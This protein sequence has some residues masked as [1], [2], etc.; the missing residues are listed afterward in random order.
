MNG[1]GIFLRE[2][3][4]FVES[5]FKQ[6]I[7]QGT[8]RIKWHKLCDL[9]CN[10]VNGYPD[11]G[12]GVFTTS[13]GS[14][15]FEGPWSKGFPVFEQT[16]KY[17]WSDLDRSMVK[18]PEPDSDPGKKKAAAPPKKKGAADD[19]EP[20]L[21]AFAGVQLGK[22]VVR[23]G[24]TA[25]NE[26]PVPPPNPKAAKGEPLL[27]PVMP[28]PEPFSVP[29][30]RR[31]LVTLRLRP[32]LLSSDGVVTLGEPTNLWLRKQTLDEFGSS[33]LRFPPAATVFIDGECA[34]S[35]RSPAPSLSLESRGANAES[36]TS[37][38]D[39]VLTAS[40]A[41]G[42]SET[43]P[44][45][46]VRALKL[47]NGDS[48][49]FKIDTRASPKSHEAMTFTLDFKLDVAKLDAAFGAKYDVPA[50]L[51]VT[52][53]ATAA[54]TAPGA[55]RAERR[56]AK[57]A[58][59][60]AATLNRQLQACS[61][62]PVLSL[63]R[64][65]DGAEVKTSRLQLVLLVP[66]S[67]ILDLC[68]ALR[69]P[70][71][72]VVG[73]VAMTA[74]GSSEEAGGTGT[75][76]ATDKLSALVWLDCIWELRL[77]TTVMEP[78]PPEPIVA[79]A[80]PDGE[81]APEGDENT[82]GASAS[83]SAGADAVVAAT[84]AG[85]S[86]AGVEGTSAIDTSVEGEESAEPA[87]EPEQQFRPVTQTTVCGRWHAASLSPAT[88]HSLALTLRAPTEQSSYDGVTTA[89]SP[90]RSSADALAPRGTVIGSDLPSS[91]SRTMLSATMATAG[92]STA[93]LDLIVD[94]SS[95]MRAGIPPSATAA[96]AVSV[97]AIETGIEGLQLSE[98]PKGLIGD[99]I[100]EGVVL[101]WLPELSLPQQQQQQEAEQ[102]QDEE[103]QK[104]GIS[105]AVK[106]IG[107]GALTSP[108]QG[109]ALAFEAPPPG[110]PEDFWLLVRAGGPGFEGLVKALSACSK[111]VH[112]SPNY[113]IV[114]KNHVLDFFSF[115]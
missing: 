5:T 28:I 32:E 18:D 106:A 73:Q 25:E 40:P 29:C 23:T 98:E 7:I 69:D 57:A 62:F 87:T 89:P 67:N 77:L 6:N 84:A 68:R 64:V 45:D 107:E 60:A 115:S 101:G 81:S 31:R 30:E 103:E 50:M 2:N 52:A 36:E 65:F 88:W 13:N 20:S 37:L 11:D 22:V 104:E 94:G 4:F 105:D 75:G 21:V 113:N 99:E 91:P 110:E 59:S 16:A 42:K 49:S 38:I 26:F 92:K 27:K 97:S 109:Q 10:I 53:A 46:G 71:S 15:D 102:Q 114:V 47:F 100:T 39:E 9:E 48:L 108:P 41:G 34:G 14:F 35:P 80:A 58:I 61:S 79:A 8:A 63:S 74:G 70:A 1:L 3:L 43:D 112:A 78:V 72:P 82:A 83:A 86:A 96:V 19:N 12:H 51:A 33:R 90:Q 55:S 95:K 111:Y 17:I 56:T 54:T 44:S 76:T 93:V 24:R 85:V 66:D